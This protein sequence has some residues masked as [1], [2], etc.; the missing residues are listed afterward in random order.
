MGLW[1][2]DSTP[3]RHALRLSPQSCCG[4]RCLLWVVRAMESRECDNA[5]RRPVGSSSYTRTRR[6]D[7]STSTL[8]RARP[9]ACSM[10]LE[11]NSSVRRIAVSTISVGWSWSRVRTMSRA[12]TGRVTGTSIMGI[13][14]RGDEPIHSG[15]TRVRTYETPCYSRLAARQE[16]LRRRR[17]SKH[18]SG[19]TTASPRHRAEALDTTSGPL[20][21][22]AR[23]MRQQP[24]RSAF[25]RFDTA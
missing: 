11:T 14:G 20:W 19:G 1:P 6:W 15:P 4:R 23:I 7:S 5:E 2:R 17:V 16:L 9:P 21:N 3:R 10:A 25:R 12:S 8:N 24:P 18:P 13:F 22:A